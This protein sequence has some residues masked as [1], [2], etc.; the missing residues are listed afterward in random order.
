M[1]EQE[2]PKILW[3]DSLTQASTLAENGI[4]FREQQY[5]V[6][7]WYLDHLY[8]ED[9]VSAPLAKLPPSR[10]EIVLGKVVQ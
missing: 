8:Y 7:C 1:A 9:H 10:R 3:V 5:D 2:E 6:I 4:D